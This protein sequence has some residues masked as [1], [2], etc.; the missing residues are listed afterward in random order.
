MQSIKFKNKYKKNILIAILL[1]VTGYS[2]LVTPVRASRLNDLQKQINEK[3]FQMEQIEKEIAEYQAQVEKISGEKNTLKNEIS[4]LETNAKKL[5]SDI[6]LT[7]KKIEATNFN[8]E[9]LDLEI[10]EKNGQI[11]NRKEVLAESIRSI[12]EEESLSLMEITLSKDN[13]SDFFGDLERMENLQKGIGANLDELKDL[14]DVLENEKN[15]KETEKKNM[16]NLKLRLVDQKIITDSNKTKKN[17]LLTKTKNLEQN[18][19]KLLADRIAKQKAL[20]EEILDI[21]GQIKVEIDPKSI[22]SSGSGVLRWPL[23]G[24]IFITQYFGNTSFATANPQIYNGGGHNGVD[25]R[26]AVGVPIKAAKEGVVKGIGDTDKNCNGVSYGKWVLIEHPNNLT[27]LYAHLSLIKVSPGQNI[28]TGE[29]V[30][31]NGETG[32]TT[33]PHLHFTVFATPGVKISQI[34]SKVCGTLMTL[35]VAARN[36]YLNPLSYL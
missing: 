19:K 23:D 28:E 1:L 25:F 18:Y 36:S 33:G 4:R 16:E 22:P 35:P 29:V 2:L 11:G 27:T 24:K 20:E 6:S 3:N 12:Y 14:K 17:Q 13:L 8:I 10:L 30:G 7:K 21:E 15:E 34:R 9:K 32:Y 26:A 5:N 31:Y